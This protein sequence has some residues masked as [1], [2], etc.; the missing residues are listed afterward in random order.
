MLKN[1]LSRFLKYM[2][3]DMDLLDMLGDGISN[4]N[5]GFREFMDRYINDVSMPFL[6]NIAFMDIFYQ[7][8]YGI[9]LFIFF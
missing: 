9:V 2:G 3:F 8:I 1:K 5:L 4:G 7:M 6:I